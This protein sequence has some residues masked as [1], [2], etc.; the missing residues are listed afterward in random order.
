MATKKLG[1]K[2]IRS[3]ITKNTIHSSLEYKVP[4]D[5]KRKNRVQ[6][7]SFSNIFI[8]STKLCSKLNFFLFL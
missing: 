5:F 8:V 3:A 4:E 6:K 2:W 7:V 1:I